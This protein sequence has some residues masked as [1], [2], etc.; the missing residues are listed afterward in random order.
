MFGENSV[1][2]DGKNGPRYDQDGNIISRSVV[3]K[4]EWY[5]NR[6]KIN[7]LNRKRIR[8]M[9]DPYGKSRSLRREN[10]I[11]IVSA[12]KSDKEKKKLVINKVMKRQLLDQADVIIERINKNKQL[13]EL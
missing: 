6:E 1:V 5:I 10:S 8:E 7:E 3:G 11:S 13:E 4:S 2:N 9:G 12:L